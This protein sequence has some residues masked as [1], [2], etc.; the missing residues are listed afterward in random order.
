MCVFRSDTEVMV[1]DVAIRQVRSALEGQMPGAPLFKNRPGQ[2][3]LVALVEDADP[4]LFRKLMQ[5]GID[6]ANAVPPV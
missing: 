3:T 4:R 5:K 2:G 1:C 6:M